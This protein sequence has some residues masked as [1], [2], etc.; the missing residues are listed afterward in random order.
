MSPP[1]TLRTIG[2]RRQAGSASV[3]ARGFSLVELMVALTIALI[4]MA[5]V[6]RVFFSSR[7]THQ[8]DEGL[9]RLQENARFAI[10]R[11][12]RE[13]RMA[14]YFG[15]LRNAAKIENNLKNP[16]DFGTDFKTA[17]MGYNYTASDTGPGGAYAASSANPNPV[18][19]P[20]TSWTPALPANLQDKVL[21]GT[22]VVVVRYL[23]G[24]PMALTTNSSGKYNVDSQVFVADTSAVNEYADGDIVVI[25]DCTQATIFQITGIDAPSSGGGNT[26]RNLNH[27]TTG[28]PGNDCNVWGTGDHKTVTGTPPCVLQEYNNGGD[29]GKA[30]TAVFYVGRSASGTGP[31]LYRA[32]YEKDSVTPGVAVWKHQEIVEGVENI[33]IMYG[34]DTNASF[35][36]YANQ[37]VQATS[38][39]AWDKV[40]SVRIGVLIRTTGNVDPVADTGTYILAA[41]TSSAGVTINPADDKRRRRVFTTTIHLRNR[42]PTS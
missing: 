41:N 16:A 36:G 31:A 6:G 2:Y 26:W 1:V 14:G 35:D 7:S 38:T 22:D 9:S 23:G 27:A 13:V 17:V 33:Q 37:Y 34:L 10:D 21:P 40:V 5:V 3:T 30:V 8:V 19:V 20:L 18:G 24:T 12:Q 25:A 11:L 42:L 28:T 15:C 29:I 32:T 39:T 4:I